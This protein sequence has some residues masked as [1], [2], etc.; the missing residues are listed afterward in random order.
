MLKR[1]LLL[2]FIAHPMALLPMEQVVQDHNTYNGQ[3]IT[4][5][6]LRQLAPTM[7]EALNEKVTDWAEKNKI[8]LAT[9]AA[10]PQISNALT[11]Q[12]YCQFYQAFLQVNN[13]TSLGKLNHIFN[14]DE[15]YVV[16]ISHLTNKI[17]TL[18]KLVTGND[19][20][21]DSEKKEPRYFAQAPF[22][23]ITT[24]NVPTFQHVSQVAHYLR[25]TEVIETKHLQHIKTPATYLLHI[26]GQPEECADSNYVV[27][28]TKLESDIQELR[29]LPG[30]E[31]IE[32]I[33]NFSPQVL[34]EIHAATEYAALWDIANNLLVNTKNP[35]ELWYTNLEQP[36]N[37]GPFFYAG[38][39]GH[40]K[41][42]HDV[43][44]G[45]E[46]M[47]NKIEGLA[48]EQYERWQALSREK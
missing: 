16:R 43:S 39:E 6:N 33:E 17:R 9:L 24:A 7:P 34:K 8:I 46:E 15:S 48:S 42:K 31:Q 12:L 3:T 35:N 28:Q 37:S 47:G 40:S 38:P 44:V 20:Y 36:D 4:A 21:Y 11:L 26:P 30:K 10:T 19:P 1:F 2:I 25:L 41:Y 13:L 27:V 14:P 22:D 45:L 29:T 5:E 23:T 32:I 18:Y